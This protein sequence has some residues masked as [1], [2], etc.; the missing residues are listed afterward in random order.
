MYSIKLDLILSQVYKINFI[1]MS[2]SQI[3][4]YRQRQT[5]CWYNRK[6]LS[7]VLYSA[8]KY[9]MYI[10][11]SG[12]C[13]HC[14]Q[15]ALPAMSGLVGETGYNS[16]LCYEVLLLESQSGAKNMG[17][18]FRTESTSHIYVNLILIWLLISDA[19]VQD[20]IRNQSQNNQGQ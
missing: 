12:T 6:V 2:I 15:T 7:L 10:L 18:D 17:G 1:H 20:D 9:S 5:L 11:A 8:N 14:Y 19:F 13:K 16:P 4:L 3:R